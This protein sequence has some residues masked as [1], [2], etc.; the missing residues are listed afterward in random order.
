MFER[1]IRENSYDSS[2]QFVSILRIQRTRDSWEL[3]V[4]L[5]IY[6]LRIVVI[7]NIAIQRRTY[8]ETLA[9]LREVLERVK[10]YNLKLNHDELTNVSFYK[11]SENIRVIIG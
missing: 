2:K 6:K 5:T 1:F 4:S 9:R 11:S 10:Q 7:H 3:F 8:C